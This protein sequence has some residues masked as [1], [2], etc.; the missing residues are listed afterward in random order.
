MSTFL[1]RSFGRRLTAVVVIGLALRIV[2]ALTVAADLPL[3]GDARYYHEAANLLADGHGFIDPV[4]HE[5][6]GRSIDIVTASGEPRTITLPDPFDVPTAGHPPVYVVYLAAFSAVGIDTVGGHRAASA[7]LGAVSIVFAGLAGRELFRRRA[8]ARTADLAGLV[9]ATITALYGF[10]WINDGLVMSETAAIVVAFATSWVGLRFVHEP[11][12]R[13]AAWFGV[14]GGLAALTRAELVLYLPI[15]AAVVLLR[16]P[17]SWRERIVRYATAGVVAAVIVSP[18]IIRNLTAFEDPVLLSNGAGTVLVQ[19]NCDPTYYGPEI[20]YW[21][22]Q[23]GEPQ[24]YGP[25]GEI[26]DEAQRDKV[27]RERALEYIGDHRTRL[28]TVVVPRRIGR[29]WGLYRPLHQIDL[30]VLVE[31]RAKKASLLSFAQYLVLA[32][33][34]VAGAVISRRRRIPLLATGLWALLATLTAASTFGNTRYR[35]AGEVSIVLL[36]TVTVVVLLE[37]RARRRTRHTPRSGSD[38]ASPATRDRTQKIDAG[39]V[40]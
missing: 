26:L 14:C 35:T 4:R 2:Y 39:D 12:S 1:P 19:S 25:N 21:D 8:E 9:A 6:A 7:L 3:S 17:L 28:V 20:G 16:A 32:P 31:A 37:H 10:V 27:V 29:M 23:C 40:T 36:S 30:D 24:P 38:H 15:V 13:H 33:A 18:W 11:S 22:L 5:F 34:A